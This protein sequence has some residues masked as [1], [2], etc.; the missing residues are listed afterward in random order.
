MTSSS[1]SSNSSSSS[2]STNYSRNGPTNNRTTHN[3]NN[4]FQQNAVGWMDTL[5]APPQHANVELH[6]LGNNNNNNNNNNTAFVEHYSRAESPNVDYG[7]ACEQQSSPPLKLAR[8]GPIGGCTAEAQRQPPNE[9]RQIQNGQPM[10]AVELGR[11]SAGVQQQ[12]QLSN[13]NNVSE[14][15]PSECKLVVLRQPE[16]QH[17][18]LGHH[19]A[20]FSFW[21]TIVPLDSNLHNLYRLVHVSGKSSTVTPCRRLVT[22]HGTERLEVML[23]PENGMVVVLDCVGIMKICAYGANNN[24]RN[25]LSNC[26]APGRK[27]SNSRHQRRTKARADGTE[28]ADASK[29]AKQQQQHLEPTERCQNDVHIVAQCELLEGRMLQMHTEAIRC[30]QQLGCPDVLKMSLHE[31]SSSGGQQLFIIGR[32]FNPKNLRVLFREYNNDGALGWSAEAKLDQRLVHQCHIV[33]TVPTYQHLNRS[34]LVSVTVIC[35]PKQSH[36]INFSYAACQREFDDDDW[37]PPDCSTVTGGY[38]N[39]IVVSPGTYGFGTFNQHIAYGSQ[40]L[41][42]KFSTDRLWTSTNCAD[43]ELLSNEGNF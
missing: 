9:Q 38:G 34:A 6:T 28:R 15:L 11:C 7:V 1:S 20:P 31:A 35:G 2:S 5:W 18:A 41:R 39:N 43:V 14:L 37:R 32:N 29:N 10:V 16:E 27:S 36:P 40:N 33:C 3:N 13:N 4:Y 19:F 8:P 12:R 22:E 42:Q 17:R 30:V 25:A 23:R 24:N 21:V 26:L